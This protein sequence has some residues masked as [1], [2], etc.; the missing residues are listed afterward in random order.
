MNIITKTLQPTIVHADGEA[1]RL[2]NHARVKLL[3]EG[4]PLQLRATSYLRLCCI[5][6]EKLCQS[7]TAVD[8]KEYEESIEQFTYSVL[9][10]KLSQ[11]DIRWWERCWVSDRGILKSS[12][13]V[14]NE[15]LQPFAYL[16]EAFSTSS[17]NSDPAIVYPSQPLYQPSRLPF[18]IF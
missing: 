7:Y 5:A 10:T 2:L 15:Y 16:I 11:H 9:L 1:I 14:I 17:T 3:A 6:N 13:P 12:D 4:V 8:S 18:A